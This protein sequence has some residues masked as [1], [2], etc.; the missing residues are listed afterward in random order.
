MELIFVDGY[1]VV[2]TTFENKEHIKSVDCLYR[3]WK[4]NSMDYAFKDCINLLSVTNINQNIS[5]MVGSFENCS[6]MVT[7]PI[8]PNSVVNI[9]SAFKNCSLIFSA[10]IPNNVQDL[11][12]AF[13]NCSS[14]YN[15]TIFPN[16]ISNM[17]QTF[18]DCYN[19]KTTFDIPNNVQDLSQAFYNCSNITQFPN[20]TNVI[21]MYQ[22]FDGCSNLSGNLYI[23]AENITNAVNCFSNTTLEKDVY[24][25]FFYSNNVH[26]KTY[27]SFINAN[28]SEVSRVNGVLLVDINDAGIDL[29]DYEYF[30]DS[31]K[32]AHLIKYIGANNA[33]IQPKIN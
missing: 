20:I 24:I 19:L 28:Y 1:D 8:I 5:S 21:N 12:Q 3:E 17:H 33:V 13:Y 30:V 14:L 23:H 2:N 32:I 16:S 31:N 18:Y 9:Q 22:A 7:Q 15:T 25:P 10:V 6:N 29:S 26:T 27:D 4:D 11:S